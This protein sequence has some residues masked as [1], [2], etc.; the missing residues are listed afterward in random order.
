MDG[1]T[2]I[3]TGGT[4]G[5]GAAVAEAFGADGATVVVGARDADEVDATVDALEDAGTTA[6]GLRTDVRDEYD[7]ERLT[8]T[9]SRAGETAGIDVVVPAAGVYHGEAGA[10]PTDDESYAAFDDH[11]RTNGR[12]VYA[13]IR[14]SLP[15]LNDGAR[16]LV[17]T[18][19][20]ARDGQSGYGSYAISKATAE[21]VTRGF[22]ADTDYVVGCLDPGVVATGLSGEAGRD[23][24][25]VAPMFVWAATEAEPTA[26]DGAVVGLR[27][28]KQATR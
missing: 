21:A 28:W 2:V 14:E 26:V 20:V 8:E 13:T 11:W 15:H 4:R 17:P 3:V 22:A 6:A 18:G 10:T 19:S 5:I 24:D 12:G 27:E 25:A 7:V 23:P 9:A 1:Q 16:V